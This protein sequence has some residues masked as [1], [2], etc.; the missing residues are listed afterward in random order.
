[1]TKTYISSSQALEFFKENGG[2]TVL[3]ARL[4]EAFSQETGVEKVNISFAPPKG[5]SVLGGVGVHFSV[6]PQA[7]VDT[8]QRL[9]E[10]SEKISSL[11]P[12]NMITSVEPSLS[13]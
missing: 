3:S 13:L 8:L 1:M 9:V 6:S 7:D 4:R 11:L 2:Q 12:P 5:E 10:G